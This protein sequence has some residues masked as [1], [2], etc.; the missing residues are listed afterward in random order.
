MHDDLI[1]VELEVEAGGEREGAGFTKGGLVAHEVDHAGAEFADALDVSAGASDEDLGRVAANGPQAQAVRELTAQAVAGGDGD[2]GADDGVEVDGDDR[3]LDVEEFDRVGQAQ[4]HKAQ[5][6]LLCAFAVVGGEE[7]GIDA[8]AFKNFKQISSASDLDH[9]SGGRLALE[10]EP[11]GNDDLER[12]LKAGG[13]LALAVRH[14]EDDRAQGQ[15]D[16]L[17]GEVVEEDAA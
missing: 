10:H 4:R 15:R 8:V 3:G 2:G 1:G 7:Q 13:A 9:R 11:L 16:A 5:V 12:H 17:E 14:Q 6:K